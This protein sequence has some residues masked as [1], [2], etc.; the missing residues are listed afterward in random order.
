[1]AGIFSRFN[2]V[3]ISLQGKQLIVFV[4][5]DRIKSLSNILNFGK[6]IA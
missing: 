1:M 2:E 3:N 5:N 4:A 6:L